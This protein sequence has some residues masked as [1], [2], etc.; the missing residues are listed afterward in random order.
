MAVSTSGNA[1][2]CLMALSTAKAA[3]CITITLTGPQGGKLA[4]H[5]N[6]AIKAPGESTRTIQEAHICLYHTLC[7]MIEAH[8]F[9]EMR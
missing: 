8:Y 4:A 1:T 9:P 5:A 7:G 2:N 6:I 3:G